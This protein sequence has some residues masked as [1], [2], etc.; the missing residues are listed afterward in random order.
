MKDPDVNGINAQ[1]S[2][3][4]SELK[5]REIYLCGSDKS[6]LYSPANQINAYGRAVVAKTKEAFKP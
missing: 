3:R 5:K 4:A 1:R 6:S 2:R